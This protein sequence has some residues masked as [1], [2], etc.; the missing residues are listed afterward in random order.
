MKQNAIKELPKL[1]KENFENIFNVY[2]NEDG[3]YYYNL[4]N[5]IVFPQNLPDSFFT[6]Y[7]IQPG[8]TWPYISYKVYDTPNLWWVILLA[9]NIDNPTT[10][11]IM[12]QTIKIPITD[13]VREILA[14]TGG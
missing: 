5:N 13:V 4:L 2:Q 1:N 14:Q 10:P 8:D 3:V 7:S 11:L 9:N 6:L 12:G